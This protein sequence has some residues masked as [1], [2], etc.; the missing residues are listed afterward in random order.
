LVVKVRLRLVGCLAVAL[1]VAGCLKKDNPVYGLGESGGGSSGNSTAGSTGGSTSRAS[2]SATTA[3]TDSGGGRGCTVEFD[4]AFDG[5][6]SYASDIPWTIGGG[7]AVGPT[8]PLNLSIVRYEDLTISDG[9]FTGS[10]RVD[11]MCSS[12]SD[13]KGGGVMARIQSALDCNGLVAIYC[14]VNVEDNEVRLGMSS[15]SC[16][17]E[18]NEEYVGTPQE[19]F[20]LGVAYTIELWLRGD[21]AR[22]VVAEGT[23]SEITARIFDTTIIPSSGGV[24][25]WA[26]SAE[27]S[28]NSFSACIP[29]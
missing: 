10:I 11:N 4:A 14:L 2:A 28:F 15:G 17:G 19:P 12:G 26:E 29:P 18:D 1:G 8:C 3:A 25:F 6:E 20:A 24:G 13:Y 23:N 21:E 9:I 16:N 7:Q 22:C 5:T 27:V